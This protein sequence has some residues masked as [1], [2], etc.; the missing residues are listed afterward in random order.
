VTQLTTVQSYRIKAEWPKLLPFIRKAL[1][2]D[3]G[4]YTEASI[5]DAL[6]ER[7]MQLWAAIDPEDGRRLLAI[8][9]TEIRNYPGKKVGT[10][11]L[12]AGAGMAGWLPYLADIEAW[13][14]VKGCREVDIYGRKG[15]AKMLPDYTFARVLLRK[16]L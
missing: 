4:R 11:F 16:E 12:C 8:C 2:V 9:I 5:F 10:V 6:L 14:R 7:Q 13:F 1:S 15:W 3:T